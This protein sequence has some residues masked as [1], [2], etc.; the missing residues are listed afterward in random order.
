[1]SKRLVTFIAIAFVIWTTPSTVT[2]QQILLTNGVLLDPNSQSA[3]K[4]HLLMDNDQIIGRFDVIPEDFSGK[5][6]DISNKF[7]IPGLIDMHTHTFGNR[8]PNTNT[9]NMGPSTTAQVVLHAG[10]TGLVDLFGNEQKLFEHRR[11][12][13]Q[14]LIDGADIYTSLS[15]LTAPGGHCS[16]FGK[17]RTIA[18]EEEAARHISELAQKQADVIKL[19]STLGGR[20]PSL[21]PQL[22][23][24]SVDQAHK[25]SLKVIVHVHTLADVESAI[26]AK[27]DAITHLPDD[28]VISK[29]LAQRLSEHGV[30]VIPAIACD[31][32]EYEFLFSDVL[33]LSLVKKLTAPRI[34]EGYRQKAAQMTSE[35]KHEAQQRTLKYYQ[36]IKNLI[37][38]DVALLTG[39]DAGNYGTL[40]G[41]TLHRELLKF[42][43]AGLTPWQALAS[44]TT[45]PRRFL[46][47]PTGLEAGAQSSVVIVNLS[48]IENIIN[49]QTIHA[50]LHKGKYIENKL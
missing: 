5:R 39:T 11:L 41:F 38:A 44:A 9:E 24:F 47:K 8:A 19:V 20:L 50:V 16:Q 40:Q 4:Q 35:Q 1:M 15:C 23:K 31:T 36:S 32:D 27:A 3:L 48:P 6:I 7:V 14:G 42:V 2:A 29:S 37:A 46:G 12:Q 17:T 10:V 22:L 33:D 34:I 25:H 21:S 30:S 13:Q 26:T 49:T 43:K 45:E 28:G 18:N